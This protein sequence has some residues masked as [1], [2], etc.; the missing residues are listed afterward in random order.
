MHSSLNIHTAATSFD[1]A[2]L[3]DTGAFPPDSM[4]TVG[5]TQ[6]IVFVNGRIR[7]FTK[8]GVADGVINADPDVFFAS[9]ST[10]VS[11]PVVLDFT[12][13]PQARFDRFSARWFLTIIDVPCTNAGCTTTAPNR[14]LFAV[15]DAASNGVISGSTVWTFFQF[16]ASPGTDFCDYPSLG[17]D[18]NALYIGCNMFSSA[19]SFVG[20]NG[21][22]VQNF[23]TWRWSAR[24]QQFRESRCGCGCRAFRATWR[25]QFRCWRDRGLF[26]RRRQRD[27]Q[28]G[29][30]SP[31]QQSR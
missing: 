16:Q 29:H 3:T 21:Y 22:V 19:G 18:V 14:L 17:I 7:S 30:V 23:G 13:D 1:G 27:V 9:V 26:S 2:T 8:A 6:F 25:R 11:P 31:H 28:H 10:P 5:P 24:G 20:T 4:G 15:S 12:S